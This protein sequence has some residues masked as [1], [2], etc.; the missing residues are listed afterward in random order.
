MIKTIEK[1]V[2]ICDKCGKEDYVN[3]CLGCG[4]EMCYTCRL[5][6]GVSYS[7]SVS[8]EGSNDGFYCRKCDNKLTDSVLDSKHNAYRAIQSLK[9]EAASWNEDF[10]RRADEAE[11]KLRLLL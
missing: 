4:V 9:A 1:S 3:A 10:Q 2:H 6:H 7:F 8:M 11:K 5:K